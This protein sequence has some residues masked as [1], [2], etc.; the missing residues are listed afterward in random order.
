VGLD[1]SET[2]LRE[3]IPRLVSPRLAGGLAE[4]LPFKNACFDALFCEC[5]LSVVDK[6][7]AALGEF[8]RVLK[9]GGVLIISDVFAPGS[10]GRTQ[11]KQ[12][13]PD[14]PLSR[15]EL[16]GLLAGLGFSLL[17]WEEHERRLREFAARMILAGGRIPD[18]WGCSRKL[19]YFLLVARKD[20]T[21]EL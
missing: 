15:D 4:A 1:C 11:P 9:K 20:E 17:L 6:R 16:L 21:P 10:P 3:A 7:E 14:G 5:V 2:L 13:G 19:S 12:P 18:R 8:N